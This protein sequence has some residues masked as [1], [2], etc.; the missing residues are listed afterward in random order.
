MN[1]VDLR[2]QLTAEDETRMVIATVKRR[3]GEHREQAGQRPFVGVFKHGGIGDVM[4]QAAF[5]RAV[6]RARPD[7]YIVLLCRDL[8]PDSDGQP[9]VNNILRGNDAADHTISYPPQDW[10]RCVQAF[11]TEFD[12]FYEVQYVAQTYDWADPAAHHVAQLRLL[13]W[14]DYATGFPRSNH[15]LGDTRK[16]QWELLAQTS[17]LDVSEDDLWIQ[18]AECDV[19]ESQPYVCIHNMAGGT[20][21]I[22]CA[23]LLTMVELTEELQAAGLRVVHVGAESDPDIRGAVNRKGLTI[24]QTA[25]LIRDAKLLI[26]IE[27]GLGYIARAVGT[28]RACFFGP[29]P[30]SL[31]TF[32][33]DIALC[34]YQCDP[35]WWYADRWAVNCRDRW[36]VCRNIPTDAKRIAAALIP[37]IEEESK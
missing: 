2:E 4:Q 5:A 6:R 29:T 14:H 20:A 8:G 35:C 26:D 10:K 31:F 9:L 34:T 32:K 21:M 19:P 37:Y 17:G 30:P 28:R 7:A 11:Y 25:A 22:K 24:N 16:T 27:G 3:I 36:A 1:A 12:V 23:P 13:P 33:R 15:W 18:P